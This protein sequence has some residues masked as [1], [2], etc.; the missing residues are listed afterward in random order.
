[1]GKSPSPV[2]ADLYM[3]FLETG[4]L[5]SFPLVPKLIARFVDDYFIVWQ[6]GWDQLQLFFNH[7]NN[8]H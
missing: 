2:A 8:Q 1:M 3:S 4:A 5:A 6:H 7:F